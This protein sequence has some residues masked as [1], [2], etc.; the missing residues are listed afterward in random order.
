MSRWRG[1]MS[2]IPTTQKRTADNLQVLDIRHPP[3]DC[4]IIIIIIMFPAVSSRTHGSNA[5]WPTANRKRPS[6]R[7]GGEPN[8]A[9]TVSDG[10]T[11]AGGESPETDRCCRCCRAARADSTLCREDGSSY[12]TGRDTFTN[13][14]EIHFSHFALSYTCAI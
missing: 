2:L 1:G 11:D 5:F 12:T 9:I 3:S 6:S 7:R 8:T 13:Y 14:S 10:L 4:I